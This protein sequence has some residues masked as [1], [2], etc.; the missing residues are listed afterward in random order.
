MILGNLTDVRIKSVHVF[1]I[2]R[3][4]SYILQTFAT[5]EDI[6][7]PKILLMIPANAPG[8]LPQ[9]K[10][11]VGPVLLQGVSL[12]IKGGPLFKEYGYLLLSILLLKAGF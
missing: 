2:A 9:L 3:L 7:A 5:I 10:V 8:K 4:Y 1:H 12:V 11:S 6:C